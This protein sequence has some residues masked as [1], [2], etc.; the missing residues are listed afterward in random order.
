VAC[1]IEILLKEN[2]V[3]LEKGLSVDDLFM[4]WFKP[5]KGSGC[6]KNDL[7]S[8]ATLMNKPGLVAR[9]ENTD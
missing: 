4:L 5:L 3:S 1:A 7:V 8:K 2:A 9:I 6:S